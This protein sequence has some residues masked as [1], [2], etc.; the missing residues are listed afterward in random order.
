[1]TSAE[2]YA[3]LTICEEMSISKAAAKLFI[4][5]ASLSSKIKT[6]ENELGYTLFL[7]GKGQR[8]IILTDEGRQFFCKFIFGGPKHNGFPILK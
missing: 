6:L 1:M 4:S 8:K 2:I 7:R 5:Q 3:F